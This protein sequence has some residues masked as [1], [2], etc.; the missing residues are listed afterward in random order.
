M[1]DN[2]MPKSWRSLDARHRDKSGKIE[3]KHGNTRVGTQRKEYG[4]AQDPT[5]GEWI[6]LAA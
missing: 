6:G 2:V 5:Q 1:E 4:Y 3:K